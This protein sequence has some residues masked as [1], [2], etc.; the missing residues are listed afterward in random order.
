M[1]FPEPYYACLQHTTLSQ[2]GPLNG[3]IA[4][5]NTH[6]LHPLQLQLYL[7]FDIEVQTTR[8]RPR[9]PCLLGYHMFANIL[10]L[11]NPEM[12]CAYQL[13]SHN[14]KTQQWSKVNKLFSKGFFPTAFTDSCLEL[15][16]TFGFITKQDNV[17]KQTIKD[18]VHTW[19]APFGQQVQR[20]KQFHAHHHNENLS[21]AF[22]PSSL[23]QKH[24]RLDP[25]TQP[26][27]STSS[28]PSTQSINHANN[29]PSSSSARGSSHPSSSTSTGQAAFQSKAVT[30]RRL[31]K[32]KAHA[33]DEN[34]KMEVDPATISLPVEA[35]MVGNVE[36]E[37][38]EQELMDY[39]DSLKPSAAESK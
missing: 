1:G 5:N 9:I 3:P 8:E 15:L 28:A 6:T 18:A 17:D 16:V 37:P 19:R 7:E 26:V 21:P 22:Y 35:G 23:P 2:M 32:G 38:E 20:T 13:A 27:P 36:G 25:I 33:I 4:L 12:E 14:N 30:S 34:N 24:P 39:P 10:D 29:G 31:G 11:A